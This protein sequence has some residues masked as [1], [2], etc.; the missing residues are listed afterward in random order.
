MGRGGGV[1]GDIAALATDPRVT[2][3][4]QGEVDRVNAGRARYEQ[5]KRFVI[6]PR[7]FE[8]AQG[9]IT[10]TLKLKRRVVLDHFAGAVEDLYRQ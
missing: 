2:A 9:E 8:M 10:P 5:I 7:D 3:L 4:V 1:E 6:L